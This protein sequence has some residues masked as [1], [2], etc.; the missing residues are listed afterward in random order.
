MLIAILSTNRQ[1]KGGFVV[2]LKEVVWCGVV[3]VQI[4]G[5]AKEAIKQ[6]NKQHI[7]TSAIPKLSTTFSSLPLSLVYQHT[8]VY[9]C[10]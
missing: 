6:M 9:H 8:L 5:S 7:P 2:S 3:C 10:L 1:T 4:I